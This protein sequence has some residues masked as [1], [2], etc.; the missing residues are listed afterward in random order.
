MDSFHI[1]KMLS[2]HGNSGNRNKFERGRFNENGGWS[3]TVTDYLAQ[4][5]LTNID[6]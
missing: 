3:I 1:I 5:C 4:N 6:K 2:I